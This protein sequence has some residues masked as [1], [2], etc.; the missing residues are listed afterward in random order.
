MD[1]ALQV[2][3]AMGIVHRDV[4]S[5]NVMWVDG[6]GKLIDLEYCMEYRRA[7]GEVHAELTVCVL[8]L[9]SPNLIIVLQG[10]P[11]FMSA[12]DLHHQYLDWPYNR[13]SNFMTIDSEDQFVPNYIHDGESL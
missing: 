2:L 11:F 4:S 3:Q 9:F 8:H 5:G 1:I 6:I 12:E 7:E 10:T 13:D